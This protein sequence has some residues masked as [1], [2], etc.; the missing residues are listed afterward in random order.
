MLDTKEMCVEYAKEYTQLTNLAPPKG[1]SVLK[2]IEQ[3][4]PFS[5]GQAIATAWGANKTEVAELLGVNI[6]MLQNLNKKQRLNEQV[7][8]RA[9]HLAHLLNEIKDY[10]GS[11]EATQKWL[12]TPN[13]AMGD[14]KP[15]SLCNTITGMLMVRDTTSI[16]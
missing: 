13:T 9:F 11:D 14:A 7:S 2:L 6:R 12:H 10:F 8:D 3:G 16:R 1:Q 5:S 4:L 15:I